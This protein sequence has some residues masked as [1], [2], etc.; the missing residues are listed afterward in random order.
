MG[1]L[2]TQERGIFGIP[3]APG[4]VYRDLVLAGIEIVRSEF[5]GPIATRV[6]KLQSISR[7]AGEIQ[8]RAGLVPDVGTGIVI[9]HQQIAE[10]KPALGRLLRRLDV[11]A[12][13]IPKQRRSMA[14]KAVANVVKAG[15]VTRAKNGQIKSL[16]PAG[17]K[18][19]RKA[20]VL[21]Q[22]RRRDAVRKREQAV[23]RRLGIRR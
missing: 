2:V 13:R 15:L 21:E 8:F 5:L 12:G 4:A 1:H 19:V 9:F 14:Q 17:R 7:D 23:L 20:R 3:G 16:K 6:L 22:K 18:L 11:K 10:T